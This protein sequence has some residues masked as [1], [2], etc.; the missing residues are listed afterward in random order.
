MLVCRH[1]GYPTIQHNELRDVVADLLREV[2]TD[3]ASKPCLQP[4]SGERLPPSANKEDEARL[5]I[6]AKGFWDRQ[7]DA[8]FDVRVFYPGASSYRNSSLAS[9]YRQHEI[10][11]RHEYG[12]RVRDVEHGSFT[13]LVCTTDGGMAPEA[14]V[15]FKRLGSILAE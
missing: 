4:L 7:Q 3:V 5:D 12:Q 10:K 13:P 15:F 2:C 1:G 14:T 11:K 8:F 9:V 6:R